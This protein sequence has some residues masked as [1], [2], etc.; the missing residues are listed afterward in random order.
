ML[1]KFGS[2]LRTQWMGA[3]ALF[4]VFSGGT[5]YAV[6]QIDADSVKSRHIVNGEVKSADLADDKVKGRD[7]NESS[8]GE[9]PSAADAVS[10]GDANTLDGL[11]SCDV[12]LGFLTGRINDLAPGVSTHGAPSGV[13]V[14]PQ[15]GIFHENSR[16]MTLS[17][18]RPIVMRDLSVK[19]TK[20]LQNN[21]SAFANLRF[22]NPDT[23]AIGGD[24]DCAFGPGAGASTCSDSGNSAVVPPN[25]PL[26]LWVTDNGAPC[27]PAIQAGTDAMFSWRASAP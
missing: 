11:D 20:P 27:C 12:G 5:A 19:L 1:R 17:P 21:G 6:T 8:L 10:A 9:V 26:T 23:M 13:T 22:Y 15:S 16:F 3:L 7:V 24:F 25:S 14:E 4:L 18:N 2:H